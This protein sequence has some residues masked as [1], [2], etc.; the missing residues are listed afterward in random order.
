VAFGNLDVGDVAGKMTLEGD[1][2]TLA[3]LDL[4]GAS[5]WRARCRFHMVGSLLVGYGDDEI[6]NEMVSAQ[7][8]LKNTRNI[9]FF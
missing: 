5:T 4:A 2:I 6:C 9:G 8:K 3:P 1:A 7:G